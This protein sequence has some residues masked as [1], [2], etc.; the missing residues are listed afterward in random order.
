MGAGRG[1]H[2]PLLNERAATLADTAFS[3]SSRCFSC[4]IRASFSSC[5]R[6]SASSSRYPSKGGA[7]ERGVRRREWRVTGPGLLRALRCGSAQSASGALACSQAPPPPS[8]PS[9]P[10][11]SSCRRSPPAAAQP[12][13]AR[14]QALKMYRLAL[15]AGQEGRLASTSKSK[16]SPSSTCVPASTP[17]L[18]GTKSGCGSNSTNASV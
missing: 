2:S 6:R 13:K 1:H 8:P 7:S 5:R 14:V 3:R 11:Q 18:T 12:A 9:S 10:V 17:L 16:S 4:A 15:A